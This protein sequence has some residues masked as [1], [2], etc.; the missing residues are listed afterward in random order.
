MLFLKSIN[1]FSK[2]HGIK[3][4]TVW[5][6]RI[7][8]CNLTFLKDT[9]F[10]CFFYGFCCN[11]LKNNH[12]SCVYYGNN[13]RNTPLLKLQKSHLTPSKNEL[14]PSKPLPKIQKNYAQHYAQLYAQHTKTPPIYHIP[15]VKTHN[16]RTRVFK[17]TTH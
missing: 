11:I 8:P 17:N 14:S 7:S 15:N 9:P 5:N 12:L 10:I 6:I 2:K 13:P 3:K 16:F 1:T 4:H